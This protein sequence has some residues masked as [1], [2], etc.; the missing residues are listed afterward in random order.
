MKRLLDSNEVVFELLH[1]TVDAELLPP[2]E[3][4]HQQRAQQDKRAGALPNED[5]PLVN[6]DGAVGR[7]Y[8]ATFTAAITLYHTQSRLSVIYLTA[9]RGDRVWKRKRKRKRKAWI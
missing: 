6:R 1:L 5:P 2:R 8:L 7:S 3:A 9:V 4:A